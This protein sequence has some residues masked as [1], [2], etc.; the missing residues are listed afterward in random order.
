MIEIKPFK[1]VLYSKENV[2]GNFSDVFAPPYDVIPEKLYDN[3]Y[4]RNELNIIRLILGQ[5]NES[6]TE[7]NNRYTRARDFLK[8]WQEAGVL[9]KD[10]KDAI[11]VYVQEYENRGKKHRRIG[12][13]ALLKIG[14]EGSD[15]VLPHEHTLSKPKEDRLNLIKKVEANLSPIFTLF[16]DSD[17][18]VGSIMEE[19]VASEKPVIDIIFDGE[20]NA[21]WKI[22]DSAKI[23]KITKSIEG[24]KV[25]IAD[26]HHRYAVAKNYRDIRRQEGGYNGECDYVLVYF[27]DLSKKDNLTVMGTHRV[28][29]SMNEN[30]NEVKNKLE[31][32]FVVSVCD[33][34]K[35]LEIILEKNKEKPQVFGY[36]GKTKYF[37][38]EPK[39][40]GE[41]VTLIEE[42][43]SLDWKNLDVSVLHAVIFEKIFSIEK[44]EGNIIYVHESKDADV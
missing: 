9:K 5:I 1:G 29:K 8:A 43:K 33:N 19:K 42:D 41:L 40:T 23:K 44:T 20:R 35:E 38:I 18:E 7:N 10:E 30:E 28:I 39:N 11:Y 3:L 22:T 15:S 6:D 36:I 27:S 17:N 13:F 37:L 14:E 32:Y 21:L 12:F 4:A 2:S 16:D 24:K 26:G 25:F 34:L 31:K